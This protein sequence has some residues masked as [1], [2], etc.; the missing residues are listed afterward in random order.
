[1][2]LCGKLVFNIN[3]GYDGGISWT[4]PRSLRY[5]HENRENEI[6]AHII[7]WEMRLKPSHTIDELDYNQTQFEEWTPAD[8]GEGVRGKCRCIRMMTLNGISCK[9]FGFLTLTVDKHLAVIKINANNKYKNWVYDGIY[10]IY[11]I[12]RFC[13]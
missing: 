2:K 9:F 8:S 4:K 10:H 1:M 5:D 7:K 3:S 6:S 12:Q 11:I 13:L